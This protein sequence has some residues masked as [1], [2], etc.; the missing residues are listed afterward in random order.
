VLI[1]EVTE[2]SPAAAAG[3]K[4][5]DVIVEFNT[6]KISTVAD[7]RSALAKKAEGSVTLKII[8]D[9]A[10]KTVTVELKPDYR[11]I[12]FLRV[13]HPLVFANLAL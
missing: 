5:G 2:K 7:L 6:Q 11:Q 8:R 12:R 10:E 1:S 13:P 3:L 4:A 9:H